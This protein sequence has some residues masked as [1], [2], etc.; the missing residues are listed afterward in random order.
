MNIETPA[1]DN[2]KKSCEK[3]R[4]YIT[5]KPCGD[6][7]R[8]YNTDSKIYCL[9]ADDHEKH[10]PV[11][12]LGELIYRP[13]EFMAGLLALLFSLPAMLAVAVIIKIDSPGPVLFFQRRA[14]RSILMTGEEILRSN[15]FK[16]V[17]G[18]ISPTKKYWVPKTFRFVKFRTMYADAR[19]RFP[20][21]YNYAYTQEEISRIKFKE[22]EGHDPRVTMAGKWLREVTLDELP[23]FW[24]VLTGEMKLVGPRPEIPEMFQNYRPE[25]MKKFTVAPGVTGLAQ[26]R[27]RGRL[28]FQDTIAYDIEYVDR[29]SVLFDLRIILSTFWKVL[30]KHGAF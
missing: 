1:V 23:N 12:L 21:L 5:I 26:I 10:S 13:V 3:S 16:V 17:G 2:L 27:G 15:K 22:L 18:N 14:A 25:Q 19:Q 28:T 11:R 20:E 30:T 8:E 9:E 7:I 24:N 4:K 6:G 29:K